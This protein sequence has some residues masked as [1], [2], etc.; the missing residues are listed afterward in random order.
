M[1]YYTNKQRWSCYFVFPSTPS[2]LSY[3]T[4]CLVLQTL[5]STVAWW[6][7]LSWDIWTYWYPENFW[8]VPG[9][10][11]DGC[12]PPWCWFYL[13]HCVSG[14]RRCVAGFWKIELPLEDTFFGWVFGGDSVRTHFLNDVPKKSASQTGILTSKKCT[15]ADIVKTEKAQGSDGGQGNMCHSPST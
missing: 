9:R 13:A 5:Q 10:W 2:T 7:V 8:L 4:H 15:Y 14:R 12:G 6:L 11:L 3:G 1:A